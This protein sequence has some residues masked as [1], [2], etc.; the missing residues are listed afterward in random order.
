LSEE[1]PKTRV[2]EKILCDILR[3]NIVNKEQ[4]KM[5]LLKK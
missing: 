4:I 2:I 3:Y 5:R 1:R